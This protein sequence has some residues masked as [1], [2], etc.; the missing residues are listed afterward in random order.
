MGLIGTCGIARAWLT[1]LG[2][3]RV[4]RVKRI[5]FSG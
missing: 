5:A 1:G 4:H 3:A 2:V